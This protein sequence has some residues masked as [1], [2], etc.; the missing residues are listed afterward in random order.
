MNINDIIES[1]YQKTLNETNI[2]ID[3]SDRHK[4][5]ITNSNIVK[6]KD[7]TKNS[8]ARLFHLFYEMDEKGSPL[9]GEKIS[10]LLFN[11]VNLNYYNKSYPF[12]DLIVKEPIDGV[13]E[14]EEHISMKTSSTKHNLISAVTDVNGFKL[15]QLIQ[16]ILKKSDLNIYKTD[17]FSKRESI[18]Y[19][20]IIDG[21]YSVFNILRKD[22]KY[23]NY[24]EDMFRNQLSY[25]FAL[26]N[27]IDNNVLYNNKSLKDMNSINNFL[28][29][30][31]KQDL[32]NIKNDELDFDFDTNIEK[33]YTMY[34]FFDLPISFCVLYFDENLDDESNI[35]MHI[36]KTNIIKLKDL[37][38]NSLDKWIEKGYHTKIWELKTAKL[39]DDLDVDNSKT[40]Y[41]FNYNDIYNIFEENNEG[42]FNT[43][44][45]IKMNSNKKNKYLS[46]EEDADKKKDYERFQNIKVDVIDNIKSVPNDKMSNKVLNFINNILNKLDNESVDK[47]S[48]IQD[49]RTFIDDY[50]K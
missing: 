50:D 17:N 16:F 4:T 13:T 15:R 42:E 18:K 14:N 25:L 8:F 26:K 12:V 37:Y 33:L 3:L 23:S 49:F 35:N 28:L 32:D 47:E 21:M 5:T 38:Q 48:V 24:Y 44:I 43:H 19:Y 10:S 6:Y 22:T 27:A 40:N 45:K 7:F 34:D 29:D 36:Q 2:N 9:V 20:T 1:S 11:A 41:Y 31:I 46:Y 39:G 30:F